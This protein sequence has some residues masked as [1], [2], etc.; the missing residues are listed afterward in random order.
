M[1]AAA[2]PNRIGPPRASRVALVVNP[3]ASHARPETVAA[4]RAAL[5]RYGVGG[6]PLVAETADEWIQTLGD[7]PERRIVLVGGDGTIHAAANA[8]LKAEL[9]LVPAG[10]ANNIARSLGIPLLPAAA[11]RLAVLGRAR[12]IDVIEAVTATRRRIVV[13]GLSVG[14]LAAARS[15]YHA[16]G[17]E[18]PGRALAA[19]A[20]ALAAF[21]P[22]HVHVVDGGRA[23]DLELAQ[24][25]VANLPLYAFGLHVAPRADPEDGLL[26]LVAIESCGRPDVLRM[27]VRLRR[28][29]EFGR[30]EVHS[31]RAGRIR[32][33]PH[34]ASPVIADSLDLGAGPVD[35]SVRRGALA[36]VRP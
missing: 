3:H 23:D 5:E 14:F 12:P 34:G 6:R 18:H 15:R 24:L 22:L 1:H 25:F 21:R 31:W 13:E 36:L 16:T 7:E 19:G 9:A 2:P 17:S 29:T 8:S 33:D 11:A 30:P 10:S 4:A 20:A 27:I 35:L 32:L 28:G 26:D